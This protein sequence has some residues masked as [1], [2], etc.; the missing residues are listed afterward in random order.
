MSL[1]NIEEI[2]IKDFEDFFKLEPTSGNN[3]YRGHSDKIGI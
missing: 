2:V 1:L 3:I